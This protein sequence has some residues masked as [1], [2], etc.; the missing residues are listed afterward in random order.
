MLYR[1]VHVQLTPEQIGGFMASEEGDSWAT[2]QGAPVEIGFNDVWR[3]LVNAAPGCRFRACFMSDTIPNESQLAAITQWAVTRHGVSLV[4]WD[5]PHKPI[6]EVDHVAPGTAIVK[7]EFSDPDAWDAHAATW[8]ELAADPDFNQILNSP[9]WDT[10]NRTST[11]FFG[12][13]DAGTY[14]VRARVRDSTGL[15]SEYSEVLEITMPGLIPAAPSN[16]VATAIGR[17][18]TLE[19]QDNSHNEIEFRI[20]RHAGDGTWQHIATVAADTEE[21]VDEDLQPGTYWYRVIAVGGAGVS[22]PSNEATVTVGAQPPEVWEEDLDTPLMGIWDYRFNHVLDEAGR[23]TTLHDARG[24]PGV[25]PF[26]QSNPAPNR[27]PIWTPD[28]ITFDGVDDNLA[29]YYGIPAAWQKPD[30]H[31]V[32]VLKF[33]AYG[34]NRV[35]I[36]NSGTSPYLRT[37]STGDLLASIAGVNVG[38]TIATARLQGGALTSSF[39]VYHLQVRENRIIRLTCPGIGSAE[40]S[41]ERS[42]L[43]IGTFYIGG[44]SNPAGF[45]LRAILFFSSLPSEDDIAKINAWAAAVH[46]ASV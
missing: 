16:L 28:G 42:G 20:E 41:S 8:W 22:A 17:N 29:L 2:A 19:W 31:I 35:V 43:S 1:L 7:L 3:L 4:T 39:R 10:K 33:N 40:S 36:N 32:L 15:E 18:V 45:T 13:D 38:T 27:W 26:I 24:T 37:T 25:P 30:Y 23:V 21:Y 6:L 14:Y 44:I 11:Q 46:G 12:L 9:S 34:Q 5:A